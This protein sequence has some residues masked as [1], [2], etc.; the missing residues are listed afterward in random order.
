[1]KKN[2]IL[3]LVIGVAFQFFSCA[4]TPPQSSP[5]V[6]ADC[7][8]MVSEKEFNDCVD[9]NSMLRKH[10]TDCIKLSKNSKQAIDQCQ[11]E[12]RSRAARSFG[13]GALTG[14]GAMGIV[15]ILLLILL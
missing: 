13:F 1:M 4:S 11:D 10:L 12:S 14:G 2:I 3:F 9:Q 7:G 6:Y 8:K 15:V 5:I